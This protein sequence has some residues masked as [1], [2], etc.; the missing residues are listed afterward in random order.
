MNNPDYNNIKASD[1][2][3]TDNRIKEIDYAW[4][5]T[6][7]A[8]VATNSILTVNG[9]DE[10]YN[11]GT[12]GEDGGLGLS[13]H[14]LGMKFVYN[15]NALC[16]HIDHDEVPQ[17]PKSIKRL[18]ENQNINPEKQYIFGYSDHLHDLSPFV[19]NPFHDGD[20]NLMENEQFKC[21]RDTWNIK[22]Y[23]CKL[24][25]I[26]GICDSL[27]VL[28]IKKREDTYLAPLELFGL[29]ATRDN[30][31]EETEQEGGNIYVR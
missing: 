10:R 9:L 8:S 22:H 25:G 14:K 20:P 7:N 23:H 27:E 6:N 13:L 12:G 18:Y 29:K 24:C 17:A 30:F 11:G 19:N 5:W 4:F 3:Y 26:E 28:E 15:P 16:Y 2:R 31:K 21:W 1:H